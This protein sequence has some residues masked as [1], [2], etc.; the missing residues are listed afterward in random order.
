MLTGTDAFFQVMNE[1][2]KRLEET[3]TGTIRQAAELVTE[4]LANGG[5]LFTVGTG[6]S[7]YLAAEPFARAGG[8][9]PVQVVACANLSMIDGSARSS[10]T[11]RLEGYIGCVLPDYDMRPGDV[12][13][14]VSNSGRNAVGIEAALYAREKGLKTIAVTN[15]EHSRAESSRHSSGKKLMDLA[16][17]VL[18]NCGPHGDASVTLPDLPFK[19]GPTSTITGAI[20]IQAMVTQVVSNL[21]A[22]GVTPP[23]LISGN[24]DFPGRED[25]YRA[26]LQSSRPLRHR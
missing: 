17:V 7:Y 8:L 15:V 6:H 26:M 20:L 22:R 18:D 3:Q 12:M 24:V 19:V 4:S 23:V 11:E 14:I 1:M 21:Q 16:D 9:W 13:M 2:I 25:R 10:R 5:I